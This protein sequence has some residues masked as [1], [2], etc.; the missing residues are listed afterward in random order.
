M[1]KVQR[2]MSRTKERRREVKVFFVR[3]CRLG[4]WTLDIGLGTSYL[5][6]FR[7]NRSNS[8]GSNGVE[9]YS[10]QPAA[11]AWSRYWSAP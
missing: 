4:L 3:C 1:S 7:I 10:L 11:S 9:M 2:P 5:T 8:S 6:S